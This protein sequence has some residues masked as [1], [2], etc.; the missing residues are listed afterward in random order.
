MDAATQ[1]DEARK[2]LPAVRTGPG[3]FS[4]RTTVHGTETFV[5]AF[6]EQFSVF[7][8]RDERSLYCELVSNDGVI[9]YQSLVEG[10]RL[11]VFYRNTGQPGF[12]ATYSRGSESW[13]L[14]AGTDGAPTDSA[15]LHAL[16]PL[17]EQPRQFIGLLPSARGENDPHPAWKPVSDLERGFAMAFTEGVKA[18]QH[19]RRQPTGNAC[20]G[21]FVA[22]SPG[23]AYNCDQWRTWVLQWFTET[24]C[25]QRCIQLEPV[26]VGTW[27]CDHGV[28]RATFPEG[29]KVILDPWRD[30]ERP[31][32]AEED[33]QT[34]FGPLHRAEPKVF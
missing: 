33:Y 10:K 1:L 9:T 12:S 15:G 29:T 27:M 19:S 8:R 23:A 17:K 21:D 24:G 11:S 30:A 5:R 31:I 2:S 26:T 16:W 13:I 25:K 32:W 6:S 20:T 34:R 14:E 28:H 22:Q 7:F 3:E 18:F 4:T